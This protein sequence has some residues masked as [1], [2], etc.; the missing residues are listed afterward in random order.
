[1]SLWMPRRW[2]PYH[3]PRCALH[4][5]V[6]SLA[7]LMFVPATLCAA[8]EK[9]WKEAWNT[10]FAHGTCDVKAKFVRVDILTDEHAIKVCNVSKFHSGIGWALHYAYETGKKPGLALY[11]DEPAAGSHLY[12]YAK[13]LCEH[14]QIT[15]WLINNVVDPAE[16]AAR[17]PQPPQSLPPPSPSERVLEPCSLVWVVDGDTL[18]VSWRGQET[19]VRMLRINTPEK[20]RYGYKQATDTL[21]SFVE[22]KTLY[23]EFESSGD[24]S[25][26]A[27]KRLLAYVYAGD[28][29]V[30]IEM[31][32]SGW[33]HFWTKFG[34]GKYELDF[35]AAQKEA[36]EKKKGLWR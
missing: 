36:Q 33:T 29:N 7:I 19:F 12:N 8:P 27:Y 30:N 26:D 11:V 24:P 4:G 1:M 21:R 5:F 28:R 32:R 14:L 17:R 13:K 9:M 15:V 20:N 35:R 23:L 10:A 34:A 31:V 2:I 22:G 25:T 16:F 18:K 6:L 3:S